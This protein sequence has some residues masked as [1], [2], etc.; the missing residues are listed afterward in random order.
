MLKIDNLNE[1]IEFSKSLNVLYVEDNEE[2]SIQGL[3]LLK[4][5][6]DNI[7]LA[8]NGLEG[9]KEFEENRFDLILSDINMPKLDGLSMIEK[10]REKDRNIS[11][12]I[13][14]AHDETLHFTQSI[15]LG[16]NGFLLKP[17]QYELFIETMVKVITSIQV[18][19]A[20]KDIEEKN[21]KLSVLAQMMDSIAHQ[22]KQPLSLIA[23]VPTN[24]EAKIQNGIEITNE[25]I[26]YSN[27][28]IKNQTNHLIETVNDFRTF[29]HPRDDEKIVIVK[30]VITSVLSLM[31]VI[32]VKENINIETTYPKDIKINMIPSELKHI[33]INLINNSKDAFLGI[34]RKQ[35]KNIN[36]DISENENEVILDYKDNAGGIALNII[37]NI[38]DL[39]FTTKEE[40][41]GTGTGLYLVKQIVEKY[42]GIIEAKNINEGINFTIYFNK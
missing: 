38:F 4:N 36:I 33:F 3:K 23:M 20:L 2:T 32:L 17:I 21:K 39:D 34:K 31:N 9:L 28:I 30:D 35:N 25:D 19:K 6:F 26:T 7:T 22:W 14:S 8:Y 15:K 29:F 42:D 40:Y 10:I 16:V 5:F 18:T 12:L 13:V 37:D 24:L 41:L 11:C 27:T 1:I